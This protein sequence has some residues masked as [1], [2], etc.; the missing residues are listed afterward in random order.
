MPSKELRRGR[1]SIPG[2]CYLLTTSTLRRIP[3]FQHRVNAE[4]ASRSFYA[5]AI[6]K[7]GFT[8]AYVVMP[9]HI[10]WLVRL[11]DSTTL[12][13]LV[14]CYK[15]RVSYLAEGVIWQKGF[16]DHAIRDE[17]ALR[18]VARYLIYNPVRAGLVQSV[19][20]YP[21]WNAVWVGG[22]GR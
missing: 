17:R 9:D 11:A 18:S 22:F 20:D 1:V 10:H 4:I 2:Q 5:P 12:A 7:R 15:G 16:H 13:D 6:Q 14:R 21:Y 8:Y 19:R 3:V